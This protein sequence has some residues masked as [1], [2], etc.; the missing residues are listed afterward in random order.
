MKVLRAGRLDAAAGWFK[1]AV[2]SDESNVSA[3][4]GLGYALYYG[5]DFS[6]ALEQYRRG[7]ELAPGNATAWL[8]LASA[9]QKA[10]RLNEEM[11]ALKR[12]RELRPDCAEA[13]G[14]L[15]RLSKD[16]GGR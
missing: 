11:D 2:E 8:S 4:F 16:G 15:N 13:A 9:C 7:L 5:G 10:G 12:V 14:R 6:G 3:R 1:K